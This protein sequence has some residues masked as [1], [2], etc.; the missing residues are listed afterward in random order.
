MFEVDGYG[1]VH[2]W[3]SREQRRNKGEHLPIVALTAGAF[4]E[5]RQH[6]LEVGMDDFLAKPVRVSELNG[7]LKKWIGASGD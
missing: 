4:E 7:V 2:E 6:C 1:L 5:D 3:R